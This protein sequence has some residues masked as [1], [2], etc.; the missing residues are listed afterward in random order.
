MPRTAISKAQG[1]QSTRKTF[2]SAMGSKRKVIDTVKCSKVA[3]GFPAKH[4]PGC[5]K[6]SYKVPRIGSS[7]CYAASLVDFLEA[8]C[9]PKTFCRPQEIMF[10]VSTVERGMHK[11][12]LST[13]RIC[14]VMLERKGSHQLKPASR[15]FPPKRDVTRQ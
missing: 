13:S 5:Q 3:S 8:T 1:P 4:G 9:F 2:S 11:K 14:H 10:R 7:T 12:D 6:G 15:G